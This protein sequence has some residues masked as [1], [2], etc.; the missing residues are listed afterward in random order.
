MKNIIHGTLRLLLATG[1]IYLLCSYFSKDV[2]FSSITSLSAGALTGVFL[3][4]QLCSCFILYMGINA[5]REFMQ[6]RIKLRVMYVV[7]A[8][9][10]LSILLL[11]IFGTDDSKA[12]TKEPATGWEFLYLL[13]FVAILYFI[14]ADFIALFIK[15]RKKKD[16]SDLDFETA[17]TGK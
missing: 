13:G 17:E 12:D 7:S 8:L 5:V 9:M 6:K 10:C 2:P 16:Y 1:G 4:F 3:F 15:K 14:V 11:A